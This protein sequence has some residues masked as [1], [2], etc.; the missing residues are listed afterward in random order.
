MC[1]Y[2]KKL[3]FFYFNTGII[4]SFIM[5]LLVIKKL[6]TSKQILTKLK[7]IEQQKSTQNI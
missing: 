7:F 6:M 3:I 5:C 1:N 4:H 2:K